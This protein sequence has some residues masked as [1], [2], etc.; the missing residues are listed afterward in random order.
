[1]QDHNL[2][3]EYIFI[4]YSLYNCRNEEKQSDTKKINKCTTI[5]YKQLNE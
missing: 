5:I 3:I 2:F 4:F 1:M